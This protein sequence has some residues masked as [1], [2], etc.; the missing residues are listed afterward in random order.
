MGVDDF[1][2]ATSIDFVARACRLESA[3]ILWA[4]SRPLFPTS[5]RR[6]VERV[7]LERVSVF[8]EVRALLLGVLLRRELRWNG[9]FRRRK[10]P[11]E[12]QRVLREDFLVLDV[13]AHLRKLAA[14]VPLEPRAPEL[15]HWDSGCRRRRPCEPLADHELYDVCER[16]ILARGD[17]IE[18]EFARLEAQMGVEV[19]ADAF[20]LASAQRFDPRLLGCVQELTRELTFWKTALV[21]LR[22]VIAQFHGSRV[23]GAA[24]VGDAH[25]IERCGWGEYDVSVTR[26]RCLSESDLELRL[27]R[28]H[29]RSGGYGSP[30]G[31][32]GH[33]LASPL[34]QKT[35]DIPCPVVIC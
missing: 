24:H 2:E 10:L 21:L 31:M 5:L 16:R 29:A 26:T 32:F 6:V 7:R 28:N 13:L 33:Q 27:S 14:D 4:Q 18:I 19:P 15:D 34:E 1:V 35:V 12:L 23:C 8:E 30:K 25:R 22:I 11:N 3:C 20:E 9:G 17:S